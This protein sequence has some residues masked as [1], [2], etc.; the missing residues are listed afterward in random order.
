ML[1]TIYI[2][3]HYVDKFDILNCVDCMQISLRFGSF[4]PFLLSSI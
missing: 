3:V 4:L 2:Y 1:S